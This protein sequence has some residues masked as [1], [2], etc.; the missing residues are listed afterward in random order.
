MGAVL[1]TCCPCLFGNQ[2]SYDIE[3][4]NT[5]YKP[6]TIEDLKKQNYEEIKKNLE[7]AQKNFEDPLFPKSKISIGPSLDDIT[8][9]RAGDIAA[10]QDLKPVLFK[11]GTSRFDINQGKIG[12]CWFMATLANLPANSKIFNNVVRT[13]QSFNNN[14]GN[15]RNRNVN[16]IK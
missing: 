8:W 15:K 14:P 13:N 16:T 9:A 1:S 6:N 10:K 4:D 12:D 2:N 5:D 3:F 11:D 7:A